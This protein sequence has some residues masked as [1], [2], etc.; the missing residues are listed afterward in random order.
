MES[1]QNSVLCKKPTQVCNS[2]ILLIDD[3]QIVIDVITTHLNEAGF[4]NVVS[5][6][7]SIE[8]VERMRLESADLI[9]MDISMPDVS[10]NYLLRIARADPLLRKTPVMVITADDS[11]TTHQRAMQLGATEVLTKPVDPIDLV[12]RIHDTLANCIEAASYGDAKLYANAMP[13]M[14]I[15]N[16]LRHLAGRVGDG[17]NAK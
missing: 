8:A 15:Y 1:N 2:K 6:S 14:E 4:W 10:G 7:D 5:T 17:A 9:L 13:G 12:Q 3:E 11:E 16:R